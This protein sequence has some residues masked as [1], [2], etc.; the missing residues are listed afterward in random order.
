MY[1]E[2][3]LRNILKRVTWVRKVQNKE[4]SFLFTD[5]LVTE[6]RTNVPEFH[7]GKFNEH[8]T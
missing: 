6:C 8:V 2:V 3:G 1:A 5:T 4:C 7:T